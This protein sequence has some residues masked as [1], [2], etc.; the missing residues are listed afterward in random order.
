M[1]F[2][3]LALTHPT[4]TTGSW[5]SFKHLPVRARGWQQPSTIHWERLSGE[6]YQIAALSSRCW[7]FTSPS[8]MCSWANP[9]KNKVSLPWFCKVEAPIA[10]VEIRNRISP[11]KY[12]SVLLKEKGVT[13]WQILEKLHPRMARFSPMTIKPL[14]STGWITMISEVVFTVDFSGE[15][16]EIKSPTFSSLQAL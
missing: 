10:G 15:Q 14:N 13:S 8:E 7:A 1:T 2:L 11:A 3:Y 9:G 16:I 12:E 4:W 6:E 5:P